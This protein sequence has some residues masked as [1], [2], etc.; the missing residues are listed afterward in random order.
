MVTS[1]ARCD[2]QI[3]EV[4]QDGRDGG[5]AASVFRLMPNFFMRD[6]SVVGLT[7]RM[8]A[9]PLPPLMR[10]PV[11]SST[12]R[13]WRRSTSSSVNAGSRDQGRLQAIRQHNPKRG[14]VGQNHRPLDDIAEFTDVA[15]PGV[16]SERLHRPAR[17]VLDDLAE[18]PAKLLDEGPDERRNVFPAVAQRRNV[19]GKHLEAEEQVLAEPILA[20]RLTEVAI[21]GR[22]QA[23][24]DLHG[25]AAAQSLEGAILQHPQ[26][27]GLQLEREL[28]DLVEKQRAA[29]GDLEPSALPGHRAR[30]RTLLATE[31]L[32]F[33]QRPGQRRAIDTDQQPIPSLAALMHGFR[34]ELLARARLAVQQHR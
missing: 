6:S 12:S 8:R 14:P 17:D 19:N 30:V 20:H 32:A 13:I 28:A 21:A 3:Q 9:A 16:V 15:R 11:C 18:L 25:S 31:Q 2:G 10:H 4:L 27:F 34:E 24:I 29:I 22:N 33:D 7:A 23:D 1:L 5:Q 26:Q